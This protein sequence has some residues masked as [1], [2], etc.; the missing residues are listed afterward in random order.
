MR[1]ALEWQF[2]GWLRASPSALAWSVL[3]GFAVAGI[4]LVAWSYRHTLR[5]LSPGKRLALAA[6]RALVVL[7]LLLCLANPSRV[8][9]QRPADENR[10]TLAVL[11]DR[12]DSMN[13]PDY[14]GA[15]R[16]ADA[17]RTWQAHETEVR[18]S[19]P[20]VANYRFAQKLDPASSLEDAA[21]AAEA[22][23][24][25]HLF[26]ALGQV[27]DTTPG[28]IVCLTDGLDTTDTSSNEVVAK[29]QQRGVPVYFVAGANRAHAGELLDIRE[30]KAPPSVLRQTQF[31]AGVLLEIGAAKD[32]EIPVSLWSGEK[33]LGS[34][35]LPVRAGIHLVPWSVDV[36]SGEPRPMP[37]EFR[38]GAGARQQIAA[39]TT[40]VMAQT[41]MQ[42]LYYQG[43]LQWGY[44]YLLTALESDPSFQ[45]MSILNPAL[46]VQISAGAAGQP[47]LADLPD[48]VRALKRFRIIVLANVFADVL[49]ARQQQALVAYARGG[50][51]VLFI[52]PN[53]E[54]TQHFSGTDLEQ[55]LPV[56]FA[57]VAREEE[58]VNTF[59][60]QMTN[61]GGGVQGTFLDDD[62]SRVYLPRLH[63]FALPVGAGRSAITEL[64]HN[65]KPDELPKFANFARVRGAKPGA[66]ILA[67]STE[68]SGGA[69]P[70]ILLA[71]Q[72]FGDGF[73]AALTTDL[74]WRWKMALPSGSHAAETFWQQLLLSLAPAPG[75]GLRLARTTETLVVKSPVALRITGPATTVT[76]TVESLSPSGE[77]KVLTPQPASEGDDRGWTV[78]FTPPSAGRWEVRARDSASNTARVTFNVAQKAQ[79]TESMNLPPDLDQ[80]RQIAEST[81]GSLINQ[82]PLFQHEPP[83]SEG[84]QIRHTRPLWDSRWLLA[85]MLVFYAAELI[86]RRCFR[87][88]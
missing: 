60:L 46:G 17:L 28:A 56:I 13:T 7:A 4:V 8:E 32:G 15:T 80:M 26:D 47:T 55:M 76:P 68:A 44:R 9:R 25:T 73:T 88:L 81:G 38:I 50:G 43:A 39:C 85:L 41:K 75:A 33:Q 35:D 24:E 87:L 34:A 53:G 54:A 12:S 69:G 71:R 1:P 66:D 70:A 23:G 51:G 57:G 45:L 31:S 74:L 42:V 72:Q 58:A 48:D 10:Q 6:L 82:E 5:N 65:V 2:G 67:V 36:T 78:S 77:K 20:K 18:A 84:L 49:T 83:A 86:T 14:R 3:A 40:Q 22:G 21:A 16:L 59:H 27:L 29:A 79:T 52:A 63:P 19:F 11:V 61:S 37:L 64:F 30:L 62:A